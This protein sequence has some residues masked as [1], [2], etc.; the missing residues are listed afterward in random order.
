MSFSREEAGEI[1]GSIELYRRLTSGSHAG[2]REIV[3]SPLIILAPPRSFTSVVCAML[4]QHPQLYGLPE[5][6][7]FPANTIAQWWLITSNASFSMRDGLH[8][9]L[10]ELLFGDQSEYSVDS[11]RG[12]LRRR[13]HYTTGMIIEE[14]ARKVYPRTIVEKSPSIVYRPESLN[15]AFAMFPQA[16][17]IHLTRHPIAHG[18]SVLKLLR[19]HEETGPRPYWL[20]HLASFPYWPKSRGQES[21]LD[22]D[23][24]R[25]WY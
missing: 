19:E 4:G 18:E 14:I 25:G 22:I 16:R 24:Q 12:W 6:Q 10:A 7:L 15:R 3:I 2:Q 8:R 23:P 9:A 11:A 17:F 20:L 1:E 21:V 13:W 5:L